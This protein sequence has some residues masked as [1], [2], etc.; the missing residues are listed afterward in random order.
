MPS[1]A[2][3]RTRQAGLIAAALLAVVFVGV[4]GYFV[5]TGGPG[6]AP[7]PLPNDLDATRPDIADNTDPSAP[8]FGMT[9][10]ADIQFTDKKDPTRVA[11]RL[12]SK[13]T[14][15]LPEHRYELTA[16]QAW[17]YA[18]DGR[19]IHIRADQARIYQPQRVQAPESGTLTGD[20][21]ISLFAARA[22]GKPVDPA[23]DR[24]EFVTTTGSLS[25]DMNLWEVT[26]SDRVVGKGDQVE[27]AVTGVRALFNEVRERMEVVEVKQG[28]YIKYLGAAPGAQAARRQP[29]RVVPVAHRAARQDGGAGPKPRPAA[30]AN[31]TYYH[32]VFDKAVKVRQLE[33]SFTA[34]KLQLWAHLVDNRLPEGAVAPILGP[35]RDPEQPAP[36]PP[37]P[38]SGAR[39]GAAKPEVAQPKPATA[40]PAQ[41]TAPDPVVM[42]WTGPCTLRPLDDRPPQL[43]HDDAALRATAED[44]GLVTFAAPDRDATGHCA[45]LEYGLTSRNLLLSGVGPASVTLAAEGSGTF[46]LVRAEIDLASGLVHFDGPGVARQ[47]S[48]RQLSWTRSGDLMLRVEN[49]RVTSGLQQGVFSGAV[50]ATDGTRT[51][52]AETVRAEFADGPDGRSILRSVHAEDPDLVTA[53]AGDSSLRA[54]NVDLTLD[55]TSDPESPSPSH[56]SAAG[57]VEARDKDSLLKGDSLEATL[58]RDA[59]GDTIVTDAVVKGNVGFSQRGTTAQADEMH[60][61]PPAHTV[62]L[63]GEGAFVTRDATRIAAP[64]LHLDGAVG[65]VEAFGPWTFEHSE[66]SEPRASPQFRA[67][68]QKMMTFNDTTGVAECSGAVTAMHAPDRLRTDTMTAERVKLEL[69]PNPDGGS[70]AD[71]ENR[72]LLKA[73]A[74][75]SVRE[76]EGGQNAKIESRRFAENPGAAG[77][78]RLDRMLY[79]EGPEVAASQSEGTLDVDFPGRLLL[80]DQ[81]GAPAGVPPAASAGTPLEERAR[82]DALFDWDGSMHLDRRHGTLKMSRNV[83]LTHRPLEAGDTINLVCE[84]LT[85]VV[86]SKS[87]A[88]SG[89]AAA[90]GGDEDLELVAADAEGAVYVSAAPPGAGTT[91]ELAADRVHYDARRGVL[92][93]TAEEGNTVTLFDAAR[94]TPITAAAL[95]WDIRRDQVRITRPGTLTTP[96][97]VR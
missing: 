75:G 52:R 36:K 30:P 56:L 80:V 49:D 34:D 26:T 96:M 31:H 73:V 94:A 76:T 21:V 66:G 46:E 10:G 19:T 37:T 65:V 71:L 38:A 22:D 54:R 44:A 58:A 3:S 67:T 63:I 84:S 5:F 28:E 8:G 25:F 78:R 87:P 88:G 14:E 4:V 79:L 89:A 42:T 17:I 72:V 15:P 43:E 77:G 48:G 20:V 91:K 59:D 12:R 47:P 9:E 82:G 29:P 18:G 55:T 57:N 24:P 32:V 97:G 1:G 83:R 93:A 74:V 92:V 35:E 69:T 68:G 90:S 6:P 86:A 70:P 13:A 81:R 33:R 64:Q 2:E 53:A 39:P 62:D 60:A 61:V 51:L 11:A 7:A 45:L 50:Q 27:F 41:A 16:P 95:E 40:A 23:V 85:G